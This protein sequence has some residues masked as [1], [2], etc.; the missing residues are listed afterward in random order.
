MYPYVPIIVLS[1]NCA[2]PG[3]IQIVRCEFATGLHLFVGFAMIA[4]QPGIAGG[5]AVD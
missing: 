3:A 5:R 1:S 4:A 2:Y